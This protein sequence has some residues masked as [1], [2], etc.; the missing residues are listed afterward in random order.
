MHANLAD[1][2]GK[3]DLKVHYKGLI[4]KG[5]DAEKVELVVTDMLPAYK[6]VI[7][8]LF[9]NALHQYCVFHFIQHIN[10]LFKA[11]LKLHRYKTFKVGERKAAHQISL[12]MLK[13]Q[14]KLT[15]AERSTVFAFCE[16]YPDMGAGYALKE[17]I[18]TLYTDAKS[19]EQ[20]YAYKDM[21]ELW[22][23]YTVCNEMQKALTFLKNNFEP[24]IAYL[25]KGYFLDKTN[26]DA[27][28]MMRTIKR[29]QQT[30]YFLRKEE[31][32]IKKIRVTLGI[33]IPISN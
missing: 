27:E 5:L 9:P 33:Q 29:T 30:H 32:Y 16:T 18:R 23:T 28:R 17:D 1:S 31:Y 12:L 13:G 6:E 21:I 19:L 3:E 11:A 4:D 8:E 22:Y 10:K 26:N 20:A 2:N 14:E 24:T 7:S 15:E 25:H